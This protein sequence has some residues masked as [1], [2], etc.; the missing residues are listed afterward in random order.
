MR[1]KERTGEI[2]GPLLVAK[3]RFATFALVAK[4]LLRDLSAEAPASGTIGARM[5]V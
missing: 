5:R 2:S 1:L 3:L 4:L